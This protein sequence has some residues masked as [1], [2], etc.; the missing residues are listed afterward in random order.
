MQ[1]WMSSGQLTAVD[2]LTCY[3]A[4][5]DQVDFYVNSVLQVNPDAMAIAQTLDNE[6]AAGRVRG[7]SPRYPFPRQ[8]Q[9]LKQRQD[10][11]HLRLLGLGRQHRPSRRSRR[12]EAPQRRRTVDGPR[13]PLRVGRYAQLQ[14]LRRL[15]STR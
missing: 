13:N 1:G 8:R 14:L 10:G 9:L 4:R 2:L 15:L 12:H 11:N 6:R 3:M 7:P 5:Y